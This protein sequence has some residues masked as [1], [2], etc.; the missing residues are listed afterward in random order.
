MTKNCLLLKKRLFA[1]FLFLYSFYLPNK[2]KSDD[3]INNYNFIYNEQNIHCKKFKNKT[4]L[5]YC[6]NGNQLPIN[7]FSRDQ[8]NNFF[9]IYNEGAKDES[10]EN[11][12]EILMSLN[13]I[14]DLYK[15]NEIAAWDKYNGIVYQVVGKVN[16]IDSDAGSIIVKSNEKYLNCKYNPRDYL[17]IVD[18][19]L[20]GPVSVKG[21]LE[22]TKVS[23]GALQ[24]SI[25][26]C[27]VLGRNEF[28]TKEDIFN[29]EIYKKEQ[30]DK[31]N[32][33]KRI[34]DIINFEYF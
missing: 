4:D 29:D 1:F 10:L 23:N 28:K 15:S 20:N 8:G 7:S 16:K 9:F 24:I 17:N 30:I 22:L 11:N 31:L 33:E 6:L 27:R 34:T 14:F 3:L 19:K 13:P 26:N 25:S 32:E 2:L 21:A 18:L 12:T 5:E